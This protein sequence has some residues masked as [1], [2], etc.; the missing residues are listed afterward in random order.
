[1]IG[2]HDLSPDT[3][4]QTV[5]C[6]TPS[7]NLLVMRRRYSSFSYDIRRRA[8]LA[9]FY[10]LISAIIE[11]Q[12]IVY[13]NKIFFW[14]ILYIYIYIYIFFFFFF[15]CSTC[16]DLVDWPIVSIPFF[17]ETATCH[18]LDGSRHFTDPTSRPS[19]LPFNFLIISL[20]PSHPKASSSLRPS[21]VK[22]FFSSLGFRLNLSSN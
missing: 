5:I 1:M 8:L 17:E 22:Y 15:F 10:F 19:L 9:Y 21:S 6:A 18:F 20:L 16:C 2:T 12:I 13:P 3:I 11:S 7:Q 4:C 14:K